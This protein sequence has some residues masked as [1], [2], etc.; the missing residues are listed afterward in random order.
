[1]DR[2]AEQQQSVAPSGDAVVPSRGRKERWY[3][4]PQ[5]INQ[6]P[7]ILDGGIHPD[8]ELWSRYQCAE[9]CQNI[10]QK[11]QL[12][13]I[14]I[15]TAILYMHRFYQYHSFTR[16]RP[17]TMAPVFVFLAA[18]VEEQPRR[19]EHVVK[20]TYRILNPGDPVV[21]PTDSE[22][23]SEEMQNVVTHENVLLQ[24][25]AFD[26]RVEHPHTHVIRCCQLIRCEKEVSHAAYALASVALHCT[27]VCIQYK[28]VE[29]ACMCID[30][31]SRWSNVKIPLS[32]EGQAW[33]SYMDP[34]IT[35]DQIGR[36]AK[37][38]LDSVDRYSERVRQKIW[39]QVLGQ[40]NTPMGMKARGNGVMPQ[41]KHET[42]GSTSASVPS[43]GPQPPVPAGH[44]PVVAGQPT[45]GQMAGASQGTA[46]KLQGPSHG[47]PSVP[48]QPRPPS[49]SRPPIP[50]PPP[51]QPPQIPP[52]PPPMKMD[53]RSPAPPPPPGAPRMPNDHRRPSGPTNPPTKPPLDGKR[54]RDG[55]IVLPR[56]IPGSGGSNGLAPGYYTGD[57]PENASLKRRK[58]NM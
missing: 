53:A 17:Y 14:A 52:P 18:K 29:V 3:F 27:K 22:K 51:G 56:P 10:G 2:T 37:D 9:L 45:V 50:A 11:L 5:E 21:L 31:A 30:V 42:T 40:G 23:Y 20:Q 35:E 12:L 33:Y 57:L 32:T 24:T 34:L 44:D 47:V 16:F 43:G 25:L 8:K 36:V 6:I 58:A 4:T 54:T 38:F 15:N 26:L 7:S 41:T 28:P 1:M 55:D 49:A 19:L 46:A 48:G 13:Q 39:N